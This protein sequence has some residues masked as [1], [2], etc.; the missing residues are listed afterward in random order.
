MNKIIQGDCLEIMKTLPDNSVDCLISDPPA[1]I[2]FMGKNWDKDKGGAIHW[3]NWLSEIMA[4]ALRV[5][6]PGAVGAVWSIPRTCGYTQLAIELA[7]FRIWDCVAIVNG[8]G[9][10]KAQDIGKMIDALQGMERDVVGVADSKTG[11]D[12]SKNWCVASPRIYD[13]TAPASPEAEQWDGWKTPALKPAYENWFLI[14]KP[15]SERSIARNVLKWGTGGINVEAARIGL[16]GTENLD[17]VQSTFKSMGYGGATTEKGVPTYKPSGR[18]PANFIMQ[19]APECTADTHADHCPVSIMNEQTEGM[20]ASK[21]ASQGANPRKVDG[22]TDILRGQIK[23]TESLESTNYTDAGNGNN[24][25]RYFKQLPHDPDTFR[26]FTK[27]SKRDRTCGGLVDN[28]HPTVKS[29]HLMEYFAKLLCPPNGVILD[30]FGGSG[31]TALGALMAGMNYLLIEQD[32][33]SVATAKSRIEAWR[34]HQTPT[35]EERVAWLET[36]VQ[37]QGNKIKK[38]E[39][40]RQLNLFDRI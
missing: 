36:Q 5:M 6:K 2:A 29:R 23:T 39:E 30:P 24:A 26:Y 38:L 10:P 20:R 27:A 18:Y 19:C 3:I 37:A 4:E 35:L 22:I 8:S 9:F 25:A 12:K 11:S 7:G 28:R 33:E 17:A 40:N 31:S 34:N 15:I 14:A 21:N 1:A 32:P 13:I 16:D